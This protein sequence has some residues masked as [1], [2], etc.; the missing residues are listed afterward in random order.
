[1]PLRRPKPAQGVALTVVVVVAGFSAE[2][3]LMDCLPA[4][5]TVVRLRGVLKQ[6]AGLAFVSAPRT[7]PALVLDYVTNQCGASE[8]VM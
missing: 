2:Q 7:R 8:S 5:Q 3:A 1:M 4:A 6:S